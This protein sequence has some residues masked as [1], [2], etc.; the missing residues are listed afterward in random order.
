MKRVLI[1]PKEYHALAFDASKLPDLAA[2]GPVSASILSKSRDPLMFL[3]NGGE[4]K[5]TTDMQWGSLIDTM[6]TEAPSV[7]A[8]QYVVLPEDAPQRPMEAMLNAAKPSASS[9]RSPGP[10]IRPPCMLL[11][12]ISTWVRSRA[13]AFS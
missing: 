5:E 2:A 8:S 9:L 3:L 7:F 12:S 13:W 1:S 11:K 4:Q 6:W 10:S